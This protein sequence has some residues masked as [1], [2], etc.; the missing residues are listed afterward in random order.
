MAKTIPRLIP[1][2]D[3]NLILEQLYK[4]P[5]TDEIVGHRLLIIIAKR[6]IEGCTDRDE[7]HCCKQ[8]QRRRREQDDRFFIS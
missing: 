5:E 3:F 7:Q 2:E 8:N 4:I 6:I 1:D